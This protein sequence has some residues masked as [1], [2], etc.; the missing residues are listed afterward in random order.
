MTWRLLPRF[1][2][3][4]SAILFLGGVIARQVARALAEK[5]DNA[6]AFAVLNRAAS[7][8]E[9]TMIIPGN[10]VVIIFGVSLAR[11]TGAPLLGFL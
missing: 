9:N 8:I 10:L 11:L 7:R 5:A 2:H 4:G 3:I 6:Q 1:L